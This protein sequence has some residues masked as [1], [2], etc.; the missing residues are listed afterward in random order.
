M[1]KRER[2]NLHNLYFEYFQV[3][4]DFWAMP[5]Q[6]LMY[7][8]CI[9]YITCTLQ[10]LCMVKSFYAMQSCHALLHPL[11]LLT[12]APYL[13]ECNPTALVF[14]IL[15]QKTDSCCL[16]YL[17]R[18]K[19]ATLEAAGYILR[20]RQCGM[21]MHILSVKYQKIVIQTIRV[22]TPTHVANTC[23]MCC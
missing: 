18:T 21:Y 1:R 2:K 19:Y 7:I 15:Q 6:A 12:Q 8:Y 9:N 5:S 13:F 20:L 23:R 4:C 17:C 16:A 22:A 3:A 10:C 11:S 14:T